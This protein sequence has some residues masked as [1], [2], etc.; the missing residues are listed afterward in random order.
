MSEITN[1]DGVLLL[2]PSE[3]A[4][5]LGMS[6]HQVRWLIRN[7]RIDGVVKRGRDL[8]IPET[9]LDHIAYKT[10][11]RP[12]AAKKTPTTKRRGKT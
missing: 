7:D 10:M 6:P 1:V 4:D 3:A 5:K 2:T 9:S 11:G 12:P 8:F